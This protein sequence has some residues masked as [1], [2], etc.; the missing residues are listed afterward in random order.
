MLNSSNANSFPMQLKPCPNSPN[1]VSSQSKNRKQYVSPIPFQGNLKDAVDK[2]CQVIKSMGRTRVITRT[3][4][5]IH[6][7]FTS[8][9]FRFTDDVEML[10]DDKKKIIHIRSASRV[11]YYDFDANR[12]RVENI[13]KRFARQ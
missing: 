5:Y 2:A 1:C 8:G 6:V 4:Y 13:R 7:E 10:F 12:K 9:V 11:G 3:D